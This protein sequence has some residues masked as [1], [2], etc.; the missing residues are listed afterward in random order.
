MIECERC[1]TWQHV[2]CLGFENDQ[3]KR[4][5]EAYECFSCQVKDDPKKTFVREKIAGGV[6][7]LS[8]S[9]CCFID[10]LILFQHLQRACSLA[11]DLGPR[12]QGASVDAC[13]HGQ[14]IE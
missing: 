3:D 11:Q 6:F 14:E 1:H 12:V 7:F 4:I 9:L 13:C 2:V 10:Q 5:P 8:F